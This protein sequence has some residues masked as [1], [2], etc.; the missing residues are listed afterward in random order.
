MPAT[1]STLENTPVT[2]FSDGDNLYWQ[3]EGAYIFW[4]AYSGTKLTN[5][6]MEAQKFP[7]EG[8]APEGLYLVPQA[9]YQ[10]RPGDWRDELGREDIGHEEIKG[11]GWSQI[12]ICLIF[13]RDVVLPQQYSIQTTSSSYTLLLSILFW[14]ANFYCMN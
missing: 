7:N 9:R 1:L 10:E 8:S 12:L 3:Q 4:D 13:C 5:Y 14:I 2:L 6:S 11:S